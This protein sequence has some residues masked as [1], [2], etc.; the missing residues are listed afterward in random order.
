MNRKPPA[1]KRLLP[2]STLGWAA[3]WFGGL[4]TSSQSDLLYFEKGG[5]VQVPATEEGCRLLIHLPDRTFAFDRGDVRKRVPGFDPEKEAAERFQQ[6][7]SAGLEAWRSAVW[8]AIENGLDE[9]A[10]AELRELHTRHPDDPTAT[11][12]IAAIDGLSSPC[13][14]PD[15]APFR[16]A[17]RVRMDVARGP[18]VLLLH[19]RTEREAEARVALLEKVATS[20][21]LHFAAQGIE[22]RTPPRRLV[23]AC[24]NHQEDY[25]QFLRTQNAAVFATTRGYFHP[26][27]NAVVMYD[28][29]NSDRQRTGLEAMAARREELRQFRETAERLSP[30]ARL[31]VTLTNEGPRTLGKTEAQALAVRLEREIDREGMLLELE[32][33]AIDE[34]TAAHEMIHLVSANSGLLPHH[35]SFPRW[36]QEGLAMQFELIRGG[37]WAGIGQAHDLRLPDWRKIQPPPNLEPLIRDVGLDRGYRGDAYAQAWALVYYLRIQRPGQFL[38]FLD[39]L[40][41]PDAKLAEL[42]TTERSLSA[43]RRAFGD[44]LPSLERDWHSWMATVKTPLEQHVPADTPTFSSSSR[45]PARARQPSSPRTPPRQ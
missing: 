41:G 40:R 25:L 21:Y 38:S 37:R 6:A 34:G 29:R 43:F 42:T 22:L 18:H 45:K 1:A 12:L 44:D 19:Q 11:R 32:R 2:M 26:T 31:R 23:A 16:Q 9:Q 7:R 33:R 20:F 3:L 28:G 4:A 24:F 39:L 13:D 5:N 30:R 10:I 27:W 8:W 36:L 35:D 14:D 17:L 15:I